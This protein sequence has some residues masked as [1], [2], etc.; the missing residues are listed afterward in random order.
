V[1][2]TAATVEASASTSMEAAPGESATHVASPSDA[3]ADMAA[4]CV[5]AGCTAVGMNSAT[6][7]GASGYSATITVA[8]A[9]SIA[10][11]AKPAAPAPVIPRT[12]ADKD[13]TDKPARPVIAIGCACVRIVRIIAPIAD[14]GTIIGRVDIIGRVI[15][16]VGA[17]G[18]RRVDNC[19]TDAHPHCNLSVCR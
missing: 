13:A 10:A 12:G 7:S 1:T 8:A 16:P 6:V 9:I 15:G 4:A 17:I 2:A 18:I 14:R 11:V 19:R 5:S 3:A